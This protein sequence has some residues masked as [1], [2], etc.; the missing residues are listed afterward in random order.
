MPTQYV[1]EEWRRDERCMQLVHPQ[2]SAILELLLLL[3]ET[4]KRC[5]RIQLIL[6]PELEA[7]LLRHSTPKV[8]QH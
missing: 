3:Q 4:I 7:T 6:Q 5:E 2:S 8:P 1:P